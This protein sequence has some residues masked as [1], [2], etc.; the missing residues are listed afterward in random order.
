MDVKKE[1]T[2]GEVCNG[3]M[4][5]GPDKEHAVC[6]LCG[7]IDYEK[8][9]G[10][11]CYRPVLTPSTCVP[12]EPIPRNRYE[13]KVEAKRERYAERA[14]K[15]R[16]EAARAFESARVIADGIPMGQ[17]I[18]VGHHSERRHRK[19][20]ERVHNGMRKGIDA[21]GKAAH[22]AHKA[23]TYGT[24]GVS[25]DD[26]TAVTKLEI[27]LV[28]LRTSRGLEKVWNRNLKVHAKQREKELGRKLTQSDHVAMIETMTMPPDMRKAMLSYARAFPWLPQFGNHTQ[29]NIARIEKRI[30]EMTAKAAMPD[31]DV[32]GD[33]YAVEWNKADNRVQIF[34]DG[35]PDP[36]TITKLKSHGFKWARSIG[37]W[38]RHASE[39][40]WYHAMRIVGHVET[41][42]EATEAA[43]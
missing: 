42:P 25:S 17:P 35:K 14:A 40:A 24:H 10:D 2:M 41:K 31:R 39:G 38:Q 11:P 12:V 30:E 36:D 5:N 13:E 21:E 4:V 27:E 22:Y 23:E 8:N 20:I 37:A 7:R 34:F 1:I 18:L 33:G 19:D 9:E 29:A 43:S 6:A 32:K 3:K 28:A 26:P 16:G 15:A